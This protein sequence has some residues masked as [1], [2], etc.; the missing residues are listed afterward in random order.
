VRKVRI[1]TIWSLFNYYLLI[2]FWPY[3][4]FIAECRL[5]LLAASGA[6]SLAVVPGLLTAVDSLVKEHRL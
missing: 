4:G 6:Y 2:Y 3:W 5:S 1:R